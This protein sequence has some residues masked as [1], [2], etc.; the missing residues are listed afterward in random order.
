PPA[1]PADAEPPPPD[2]AVDAAPAPLRT[3]AAIV[4]VIPRIDA[5]AGPGSGSG[6]ARPTGPLR[7]IWINALP[8]AYFTIDGDPKQYETPTLLNLPVGPHRVT[9]MN[10]QLSV[11][12]T[13]TVTVPAQGEA[14]HVEKMN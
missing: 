5:G 8:C 4:R 1:V 6:S 9:F 7:P 12:R 14:R 3:D 2:A 11:S 10:P 13:V